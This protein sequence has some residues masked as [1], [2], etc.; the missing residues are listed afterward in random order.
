M[1]LN[2]FFFFQITNKIIVL[3]AR[4]FRQQF[5][6]LISG[7]YCVD[8][9][10][11]IK[12]LDAWAT[13]LAIWSSGKVDIIQYQR[14]LNCKQTDARAWCHLWCRRERNRR[15]IAGHRKLLAEND[16]ASR[17]HLQKFCF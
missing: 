7:A 6:Y 4:V 3:Q 9:E 8:D 15:Q 12:K 10:L 11:K 17:H 14:A 2:F 16:A 1:L 5:A 13:A